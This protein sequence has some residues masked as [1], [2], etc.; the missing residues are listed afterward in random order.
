MK[1]AVVR[2]TL[3]RLSAAYAHAG[4]LANGTETSSDGPSGGFQRFLSAVLSMRDFDPAVDKHFQ[5]QV[6]ACR[7]DLFDYDFVLRFETMQS[8]LRLLLQQLDPRA[9]T[10]R[11]AHLFTRYVNCS[12][13]SSC[14]ARP[15]PSLDGIDDKMR[16]ALQHKYQADEHWRLQA[17][18]VSFL[19]AGA[20]TPE[21][22]SLGN[23][24]PS[25]KDKAAAHMRNLRR[26]SR[27]FLSNVTFRKQPWQ[28]KFANASFTASL[29]PAKVRL[30]R[31]GS[32]IAPFGGHMLAAFEEHLR[33]YGNP[34]KSTAS[35]RN[36]S[37]VTMRRVL[38]K[39]REKTLGSGYHHL[40]F[41]VD[42]A[43]A[44]R[45]QV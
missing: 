20:F 18:R 15:T 44:R 1:L 34:I 9:S 5:P 4:H 30:S 7:P 17:R 36:A 8:D 42:P 32:V 16:L 22:S 23:V 19:T 29:G 10:Q 37:F 45:L 40:V 35:W 2:E 13:T 24:A 14:I 26:L 6:L 33:T 27:D 3:S 39:H 38:R 11:L 25:G 12:N 21:S 28:P 31:C 43:D 41:S